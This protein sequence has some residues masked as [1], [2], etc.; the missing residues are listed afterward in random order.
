MEMA[1]GRP[2]LG[3]CSPAPLKKDMPVCRIATIDSLFCCVRSHGIPRRGSGRSRGAGCA[4]GCR[5]A[6]A[7]APRAMPRCGSG[8]SSRSAAGAGGARLV[9]GAG[10]GSGARPAAAPAPGTAGGER[11]GRGAPQGRAPLERRLGAQCPWGCRDRRGTEREGT[12]R[13]GFGAPALPFGPA[14]WTP[15]S[16][17]TLHRARQ[18]QQLREHQPSLPGVQ[19]KVLLS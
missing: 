18:V 10:E 6:G 5:G 17:F 15:L 19:T 7:A 4:R 16:P 13:E 8:G 2:I 12:A 9:S 3:V 1:K 11:S 14:R